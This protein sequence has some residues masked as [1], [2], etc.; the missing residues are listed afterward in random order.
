MNKEV[1]LHPLCSL[2]PRIA[3]AEFQHLKEDIIANGQ[4]E[5]IMLYDGMI[6][7]GGNRYRA[8]IEA[9]IKPEFMTYNGTDIVDFVLSANLH[10]RHLTTGQQAAIVS[11]TQD[12]A[13]AH[14]QGGTGKFT[15]LN[16]VAQRS[17]ISGASDKTQRTADNLAKNHP[18]LVKKVARG[19]VTLNAAAKE[20]GITATP[21]PIHESGPVFDPLVQ[22]LAEAEDTIKELVEANE[23]LRATIAIGKLSPEHQESAAEIIKKLKADVKTL[24]V[25][26]DSTTIARDTAMRELAEMKAQLL[27]QQKEIG[28]LKAK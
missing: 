7:D 1:E 22:V 12:W 18:E 2:F 3:G 25:T 17:G 13:K 14:K 9:E 16:T 26:L 28:R 15:G 21:K 6:L 8:C 19:E 27:R 23:E 11:S 4:R 24:T 10:R 5:P 20:A